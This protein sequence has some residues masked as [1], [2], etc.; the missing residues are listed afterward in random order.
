[1]TSLADKAILSGADNRLPMLEKDMYD[2]W[3]SRMELYML[4]RQHRRMILESV[5][6]SPLLWPTVEENGV[7]RPKKYSELSATK[8]F[9]LT[10]MSRQQISFSK[11]FHQRSMHREC[12]LYDEFDKFA[13]KK[14]ESLR[15]FY[16][17]FSL[18]LNDMNIYNMKLEQI[19]VN[20]KF[21]NTLPPEWSKFV[22]DVKLVR[23]LHT[24]NVDQL[25]AYLGQHE[26]HPNEVRLMHKRTCD[27]L[28]LVANHQMNKSPYQP[29]QQSYHQH[30]FQPQVSSFR[31]S[32]YGSPYH[33]SQYASQAQSSTPLSITYPS[34]DFQSTVHHNV[35]NPSSSIPQVE[36]ASSVH[37]QSDFSQPDTRLVVPLRNSSNPH[38]QATINNG[39]VTIQPIQRRQNSLTAGHMSKQCTKPKRKRDEVWF[40]DKYVVTNNAAY[41]ANDLDTYDSDCDEINSA[42]IALMANLSHY[43]S[44]NLDEVHN[45][46][47]VTNNVIDQDVQAILTSKQSNILNQSE[48]TKRI[49]SLSGNVKEEKIKRELEEIEMINI[50]LDHRVTKLV[51]ENEHLK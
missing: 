50:G 33:F 30:Q 41:Q 49:E 13:Y 21:L 6:N 42:K 32:Q 36:Y 3:K 11:D 29:H 22:T 46:D 35:Y 20:M 7:T 16:L 19:Q 51:A 37:Q 28:A 5:K 14:E 38:Q 12:K 4:N 9:K 17:R 23:D 24:T 45:Q 44:D 26:Y 25:Y 15:D 43:G 31:S 34:N 27:P 39:R 2:S 47:N 40:K 48:I 10:V 18:L 8:Q 1:M